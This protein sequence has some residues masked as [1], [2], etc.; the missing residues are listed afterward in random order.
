MTSTALAVKI[1]WLKVASFLQLDQQELDARKR[2]ALRP[3]KPAITG[4][5]SC[6]QL[7][8]EPLT[9]VSY[10]SCSI[11]RGSL[12]AIVW[13]NRKQAMT[14]PSA[15]VSAAVSGASNTVALVFAPT[16]VAE[17]N[18]GRQG[19][20]AMKQAGPRWRRRRHV[21]RQTRSWRRSS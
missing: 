21:Y 14:K 20:R 6:R 16:G 2:R 10:L 15:A 8:P 18:R 4:P 1:T 17:E 11:L 12:G 7:G 19:S 3:R 13:R 5:L 9:T